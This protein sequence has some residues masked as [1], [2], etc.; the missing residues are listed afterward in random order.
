MENA[1][2]ARK[3]ETPKQPSIFLSCGA[4]YFYPT[5]SSTANQ[6]YQSFLQLKISLEKIY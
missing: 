5:T 3:V 1:K 4:P 6:D 2:R